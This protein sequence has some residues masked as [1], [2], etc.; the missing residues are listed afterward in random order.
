MNKVELI[1]RF[2][3]DVEIR[4]TQTTNTMVVNFTLAVNRRYKKEGEPDADFINCV[5]WGKT[6][7]FIAKHFSKGQ[8]IGAFGR[9]QTRNFE[10][11]NGNKKFITEIIVEEVYFA[12][13]KRDN[14]DNGEPTDYTEEVYAGNTD[15]PF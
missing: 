3:K 13:D 5:A 8:Q 6:A 9:I 11:Q 14:N 1:G 15:L 2:T 12:G 10:D 7:E 4:Y